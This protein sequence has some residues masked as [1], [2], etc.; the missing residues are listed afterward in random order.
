[1]TELLPSNSTAWERAVSG[2]SGERRPIDADIVRRV[3]DPWTC[4]AHILPF[5]A[6]AFSV[7]LWEDDW[8]E[9]RQ[10]VVIA[11][12]IRDQRNI[13]KLA[14]L[15]AY[16][17]YMDVEII[18]TVRPPAR[19]FS[20]RTMTRAEREAWL[21][22]L[23]Q[24]RTFR[25]LERGNARGR[26]FSGG[27]TFKQFFATSPEAADEFDGGLSYFAEGFGA[28]E[29]GSLGPASSKGRRFYFP[30]DAAKRTRRR[31]RWVVDGVETDARVENLPLGFQVFG[32]AKAGG[33]A[34]PNLRP[35][36]ARFFI[37][38]TAA[39]R[40]V[41]IAPVASV[42]EW[43]KPVGPQLVPV[44]AEPELVAQRGLAG[45]AVFSGRCF[46]QYYLPS[47]A[48]YRLFERYAVFK[49]SLAYK[50]PAVQFMGVGRYGAPPHTAEV[51]VKIRGKRSAAQAGEGIP[52][53]KTRFWLPHNPVPVIRACRAAEAAR[54]VSDTVLLNTKTARTFTAGLPFFAGI[55]S[56][57]V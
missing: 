51:R 5:L 44:T 21:S 53:P 30:N 28:S 36:P 2:A 56:F 50:R 40:I 47:T 3:W 39:E 25:I 32:K 16:L 1:M 42:G 35:G 26:C 11:N 33:A 52:I 43:R 20:G 9:T 24:V 22:E 6:H 14:G 17:G 37:P 48:P 46:G 29:E 34:Y 57:T 19:I 8:S 18:S 7:D 15:R 38:S 4:P 10:R 31:A 55:D 41:S 13:G 12:A 54:R 23:P 49:P 27:I 45:G